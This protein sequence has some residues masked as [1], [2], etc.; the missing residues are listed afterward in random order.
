MS[1]HRIEANSFRLLSC[2][3]PCYRIPALNKNSEKIQCRRLTP[4]FNIVIVLDVENFQWK[5]YCRPHNAQPV[6]EHFTTE[7]HICDRKAS[8]IVWQTD[9]LLRKMNIHEWDWVFNGI[10]YLKGQTFHWIGPA[11]VISDQFSTILWIYGMSLWWKFVL[12]KPNFFQESN[13]MNV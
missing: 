4:N 3:T 5:P 10:T 1:H 11:W 2:N 6:T 13:F 12:L 7:Y 9:V 8:H